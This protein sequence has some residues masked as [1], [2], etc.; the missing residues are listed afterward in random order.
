[1]LTRSTCALLAQGL[2]AARPSSA[3]GAGKADVELAGQ[4]A[5]GDFGVKSSLAM[6]VTFG[7]SCSTAAKIAPS[8]SKTRRRRVAEPHRARD[9]R[10]A[11]RRA[12][13]ALQSGERERR[14][15]RSARPG[16]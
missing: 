16:S 5:A 14:L 9:A 11:R 4:D 12:R 2:G 10:P 1:L 8:V 7:L 13:R 6:T 15:S 3:R